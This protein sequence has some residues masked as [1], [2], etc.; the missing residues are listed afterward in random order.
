MNMIMCKSK[1]HRA[2]VTD[3]ILDYEGSLEIY[4][5]IMEEAKTIIPKIL[6]MDSSNGIIGR[7]GGSPL[8]NYDD[9]LQRQ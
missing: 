6:V 7:K 8:A 9:L 5:D 3:S 1:I 4:I 2:I